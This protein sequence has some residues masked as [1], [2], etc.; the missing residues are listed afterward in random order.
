MVWMGKE[1]K[2]IS[3]LPPCHEQ[4]TFHYTRLTRDPSNLVLSIP[5]N[6]KSTT[7]LGNII[8]HSLFL[9]LE[10]RWFFHSYL[11]SLP[12]PFW[13]FKKCHHLVLSARKCNCP[14]T[15]LVSHYPWQIAPALAIKQ[16]N[17]LT[18][19]ELENSHLT[20]VCSNFDLP[21]SKGDTRLAFFPW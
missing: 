9:H 11:S 18:E 7:S 13:R 16:Q 15:S 3:F 20:T 10:G 6:G 2:N 17:V 21:D 1:L 19:N 5:S 8:P 12:A 4:E 14:A